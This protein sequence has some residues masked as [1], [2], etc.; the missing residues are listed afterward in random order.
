MLMGMLC[1]GDDM[2]TLTSVQLPPDDGTSLEEPREVVYRLT[3][4]DLQSGISKYTSFEGE[5]EAVLALA[6]WAAA[7]EANANW[8]DA[9]M[10]KLNRSSLADTLP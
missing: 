6:A 2:L 10:E 8:F 4:T 1:I 3:H 9:S 7:D 5:N